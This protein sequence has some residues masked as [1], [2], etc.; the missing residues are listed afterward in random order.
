MATL[1][2]RIL[3]EARQRP[4][5]KSRNIVKM[6]DRVHSQATKTYLK[7]GG[8]P[9]KKHR[10]YPSDEDQPKQQKA[11]IKMAKLLRP[12]RIRIGGSGK[13][14]AHERD[15]AKRKIEGSRGE[16]YWKR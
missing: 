4:N 3:Y 1:F 11:Q 16:R 6:M 8:D 2:D 9:E 15:W 12:A 13:D 14:R 5:V 10:F 7:G